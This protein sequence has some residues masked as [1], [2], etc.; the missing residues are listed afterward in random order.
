L[1]DRYKRID[2][3]Y[4]LTQTLP[5]IIKGNVETKL[6]QTHVDPEGQMTM[7]CMF[8]D[9]S[10]AIDLGPTARGGQSDVVQPGF[11]MRNSEIGKG[12]LSIQGFFYRAYCLNG[13]VF[14]AFDEGLEFHRTHL[15]SRVI[16][17]T[18]YEILSDESKKLD[19]AAIVSQVR[20]VMKALVDP[21]LHQ[22]LKDHLQAARMSETM[23]SPV[24]AMR[25]L[26]EDVSL[27]DAESKQALTN[28]LMDGDLSRWGAVNAVTKLA[29]DAESIERANELEQIGGDLLKLNLRDWNRVA[30]YAEAA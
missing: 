20:D 17:G 4:L 8:T 27:S 21:Q 25:K 3:D 11:R 15:G 2:N 24:D 29:N 16:E 30:A 22:L 10:L 9:P 14:G 19:D 7:K 1:S 26:G 6:L 13:C 23:K 28:L 5:E 18:D 12:R